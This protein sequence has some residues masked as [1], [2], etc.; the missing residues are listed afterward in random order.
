MVLV[1][2]APTQLTKNTALSNKFV[3]SF[4]WRE[5]AFNGGQPVFEYRISYDQAAG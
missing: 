2:D 3:I 1:P 4:T 5:A